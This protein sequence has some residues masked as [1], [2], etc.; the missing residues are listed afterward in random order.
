GSGGLQ[1][2]T[3]M[4]I[5]RGHG[6]LEYEGNFSSY[7]YIQLPSLHRIPSGRNQG[8]GKPVLRICALEE[9][10]DAAAQAAIRCPSRASVPKILGS[11]I[12]LPVPTHYHSRHQSKPASIMSLT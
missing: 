7:Q 4:G 10:V 9:G 3:A 6:P 5:E 11:A 1:E 2:V 12:D 8:T